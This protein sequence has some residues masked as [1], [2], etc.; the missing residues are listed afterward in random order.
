[1]F[2]VLLFG[3]QQNYF[4]QE[5]NHKI[6]VVFNPET[7]SINA[8][9]ETKYINNSPDTLFYIY[10]HLWPDAYRNNETEFAK[11][12][13]VLGKTDFYYSSPDERGYIDS[14]SFTVNGKLA[15]LNDTKFGSDVKLLVLPEKLAP[16]D[17][18][19]IKTPFYVK[20]PK[21]F[22]RLG[23]DEN[24]FCLTQWYPKPA[25]YDKNGWNP[26]SY[27]DMAEF[28]SEFGNF[29]VEITLPDN[30]IVAASG[31]LR[32]KSELMRVEDYALA[33]E[34]AK[35]KDNIQIFGD[36]LKTKT[37]IFEGNNMH[38]FAW[39]ASPDF[40]VNLEYYVPFE[41]AHSICCQTYF[42]KNN[43]NLW[44]NSIKYVKQA[45]NFYSTEIGLYPYSSCIAVAGPLSAGG[46]MEYPGITVVTASNQGDLENVIIHEIGHNWF[47][48]ILASN[49]RQDPWIDEGF[50][51]Y[52]EC[53]YMDKYHPDQRVFGSIS[54]SGKMAR[55][56]NSLPARALRGMAWMYLIKEN[57]QQSSQLSSVEMSPPNYFIMSYYK[58][59]SFIYMIEKYLGATEFKELMSSF[60]AKY[61]FTHIYPETV[62]D[63][64]AENGDSICRS[65]FDNMLIANNLP[66]YKVVR[67]KGDSI[68]I[69]NRR[70][71]YA[72]LF[73]HV[74]DSLL[75]NS[76][77]KG[78]M[79]FPN[80]HNN[81]VS[82]DKDLYCQDYNRSNNYYSPGFFKSS[83]KIRIKLFGLVDI[84]QVAEIPLIP[85]V[86]YNT[87]D[88]WMPGLAFYSLP[89]PKHRFE[90]VIAPLFGT[91]TKNLTGKADFR[92]YIHPKKS[93]IREAELFSENSAFGK[94]RD[95]S[96]YRIRNSS[97]IKFRLRTDPTLPVHSEAVL[98]NIVITEFHTG[99]LKN[100]QEF[101]LS[102]GHLCKI[103]PYSA[104]LSLQRGKG[105]VKAWVD[106]KYT[107][108]YLKK[109]SG[110][111]IR[112]FGGKFLYHSASYYGNYNFRLSGNTGFQ[113]YLYDQTFIGRSDDVRFNP[114]LFWSHQFVRNHGGF[115]LYTP[116]GQTDNWLGAINIYS[117]TPL[118]FIDLYFN[119]GFCNSMSTEKFSNF[120]YEAGV[121]IKIWQDFITVYFPVTASKEIWQTSNDIYTDNYF[122]K[123]RFTLS[124]TKINFREYRSKPFL[125]F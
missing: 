47:Y 115:T 8:N 26:M 40:C 49:E 18:I 97:G 81:C 76:G 3:Q 88:S 92:Y 72:P 93:F 55:G 56:V 12:Q 10:Y 67:Q 106:L 120:Y 58:P 91:R 98:R 13:V 86:G 122:Q 32:T 39:F 70:S 53:R 116:Y 65:Y 42:N 85:F 27:L 82:I 69:K 19:L 59:V 61:K 38:D 71:E 125:L 48:G 105:F 54:K 63:Y 62:I 60:F 79:K 34:K 90:Y 52:Y 2:P 36:S 20:I 35:N 73:L 89:I 112:V 78:K 50:T 5:V 114:E 110:L 51:S 25:V 75:I 6:E 123:I 28:Y 41:G 22:S 23:Y 66:D 80:P 43:S 64:F 21:M 117:S 77:F 113:D 15:F 95:S 111:K 4:Q 9:I 17:T 24:T 44:R 84:P 119:T 37:I 31:R 83:K 102:Y 100:F 99:K 103:N 94:F 87:S 7:K 104:E 1:M 33:C 16:G 11:Q 101:S 45:V 57:L 107:I 124:L 109:H 14:L 96:A 30:Y 74:G 46:G 108:S 29:E 68:I 118:S 121:S